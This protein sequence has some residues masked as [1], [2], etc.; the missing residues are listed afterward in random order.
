MKYL[1]LSL[2]ERARREFHDPLDVNNGAYCSCNESTLTTNCPSCTKVRQQVWKWHFQ[3]RKLTTTGYVKMLYTFSALITRVYAASDAILQLSL[4]PTTDRRF[5]RTK[6]RLC[7]Y[8]SSTFTTYWRSFCL[9]R[10][11]LSVC[12]TLTQSFISTMYDLPFSVF[13]NTYVK[14]PMLGIL[15]FPIP[16]GASAP[17]WLQP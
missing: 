15:F 14:P 3:K 11:R 12:T 9:Q 13:L 10:G 7:T 5:G 2:S 1:I 4:L 8:L 16:G 6:H 17:S